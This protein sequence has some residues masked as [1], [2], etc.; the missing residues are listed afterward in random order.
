LQQI[1]AIFTT[2]SSLSRPAGLTANNPASQMYDPRAPLGALNSVC[3][4]KQKADAGTLAPAIDQENLTVEKLHAH[5]SKI[6]ADSIDIGDEEEVMPWE[7]E[8][9]VPTTSGGK[10]KSPNQIRNELQKYLDS[11][12]RTTKSVMDEMR[13]TNRGFYNFM[14]PANYKNQWSATRSDTYWAAAKLLAKIQYNEK[15]NKKRKSSSKASSVTESSNKRAK[16]TEARSE[17]EEWMQRVMAT[18]GA[19]TDVVYDSCP[20]VIQKI[21]KCFSDHPGLSKAAFCKV[22]LATPMHWQSSWH[23]RNK[24][25]RAT[26]ST[27]APTHFWKS[28]VS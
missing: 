12:G 24:I 6:G 2:M 3:N 16:T 22:A 26:L 17:A 21:K 14:N 4:I 11:C 25:N 15:K 19:E 18:T 8:G 5:P 10:Q 1:T 13:V 27:S 7:D 23:R 28:F 9:W 20:Q